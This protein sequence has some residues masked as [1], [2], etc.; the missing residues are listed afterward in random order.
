MG[1]WKAGGFDPPTPNALAVDRRDLLSLNG[2]ALS[3]ESPSAQIRPQGVKSSKANHLHSK[4]K[5]QVLRANAKATIDFTVATLK[6]L[7]WANCSAKYI[8][9]VYTRG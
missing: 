5:E 3:A 2:E 9:F 6:N 1:K 4:G 8:Y 7:S